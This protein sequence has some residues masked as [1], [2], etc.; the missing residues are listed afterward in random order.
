MRADPSPTSATASYSAILNDAC[1]WKLAAII[2]NTPSNPPGVA[3]AAHAAS[4]PA[5]VASFITPMTTIGPFG[6]SGNSRAPMGD[7]I[8]KDIERSGV[9]TLPAN[10]WPA[11]E[12][13]AQKAG[14]CLLSVTIPPHAN[15]DK[16]L[17]HLG[18]D[19]DFPP[20]YGANFDA[21]FDCLTAPDWRPAQSHVIRIKGVAGLRTTA[22]EDFA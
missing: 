16:A 3:T 11:I 8:F 6:E 10:R 14:L 9:Y 19:L 1:H 20:W 18:A 22:P 2:A 4:S 7:H 15:K 17:V 21:L 13:A 5:S 12:S